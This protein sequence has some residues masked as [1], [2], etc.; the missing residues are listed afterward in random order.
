MDP[1]NRLRI[2]TRIHFALLRHFD[3]DVAVSAL[4]AGEADAREA[5]WVCQASQS[6][7]L[8]ALAEQFNA[9]NKQEARASR[10]RTT[11]VQ[12]ASK[13]A[14]A[15]AGATPQDLAWAQDSSGFGVSRLPTFLADPTPT[16]T[17]WLKPSNWLRRTAANGAN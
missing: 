17:D 9:A 2:A 10:Q 16:I 5:L 8:V 12:S 4:L 3:E 6:E 7:E 1:T 13:A 15:G 11:S 14:A